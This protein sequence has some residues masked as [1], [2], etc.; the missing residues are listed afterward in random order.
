MHPSAPAQPAIDRRALLL[1]ASTLAAGGLLVGG[2]KDQQAPVL[3]LQ[4]LLTN[5]RHIVP[6]VEPGELP[7]LDS[8]PVP[9]ARVADQQGDPV[10]TLTSTI[11]P[12]TD[13][14]AVVH[15]FAL[16]DGTIVGTGSADLAATHAVVAGTGGYAGA[17]G[18][19]TIRP[20]PDGH[21]VTF[22]FP[23]GAH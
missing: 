21:L 4:L 19:Y 7:P 18:T 6:G 8:R 22:S 11:V 1:G 16:P 17:A 10:G 20:H 2:A 13:G 15:T 9:H 14:H 3:K 12:S 5:L 23:K